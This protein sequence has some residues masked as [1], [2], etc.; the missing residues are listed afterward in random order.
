MLG[1][2]TTLRP[3]LEGRTQH[4]CGWVGPQRWAGEEPGEEKRALIAVQPR[5]GHHPYT[6]GAKHCRV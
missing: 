4:L 1:Q 2:S 6:P 3:S 5:R